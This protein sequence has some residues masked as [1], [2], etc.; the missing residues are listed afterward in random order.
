MDAF[1][2]R[3][4]FINAFEKAYMD[5]IHSIRRSAYPVHPQA[6]YGRYG[7]LEYGYIYNSAPATIPIMILRPFLSNMLSTPSLSVVQ[8]LQSEGD[9]SIFWVDT[10]GWLDEPSE[11]AMRAQSSTGDFIF[12][13]NDGEPQYQLT[14]VAN[15]KV[16]AF[17]QMHLCHY[18]ASN[19]DDCAFL[20]HEAGYNGRVFRPKDRVI[21]MVIEQSKREKVRKMFWGDK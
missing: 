17:L 12:I 1:F 13:P 11:S 14:E 6:I 20:R 18:L 19:A 16:T 10:S 2:R 3:P 7:A 15:R 8:K 5:L 9:R 4:D 21:D